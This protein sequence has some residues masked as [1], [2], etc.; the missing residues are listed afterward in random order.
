MSVCFAC[1]PA[2]RPSSDR[3][4]PAYRQC[5][6]ATGAAVPGVAITVLN[7]GTG[8]ER[9]LV[10]SETGDYSFPSLAPGDY[11]VTVSKPGFHQVKREGIRLEVSQTARV[12]FTLEIGAV[13]ET[14]EVVGGAPLI[15]SDTSSIGQVIE[16][17]AIEDLPLNGRNFVQLA[18]PA[19]GWLES[20][21]APRAPS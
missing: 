3:P 1:L 13:S 14:V 12:D 11:T 6:D 4:P 10:S 5:L 18:I 17:R 21:S 19:P 20:A 7:V 16:T 15:D 9:R 8:T 2:P